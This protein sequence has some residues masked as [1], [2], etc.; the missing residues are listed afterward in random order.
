MLRTV[1]QLH[2][3][4][5]QNH[6]QIAIGISIYVQELVVDDYNGYLEES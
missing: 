3:D 1:L 2:C 5:H 4:Y 6:M